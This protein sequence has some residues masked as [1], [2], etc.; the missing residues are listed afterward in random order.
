MGAVRY[1][2][3]CYFQGYNPTMNLIL[4]LN[5]MTVRYKGGL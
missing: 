2:G 3:G 4:Y 1:I 5:R